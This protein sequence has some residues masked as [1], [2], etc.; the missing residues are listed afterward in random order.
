ML[1]HHAGGVE[2]LVLLKLL[3][4]DLL[5]LFK[6]DLELFHLDF[7][8]LFNPNLLVLFKLNFLFN[9]GLQAFLFQDLDFQLGLG[10]LAPPP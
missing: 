7:L 5:G 6:L 8:E 10:Q 2:D 3:L 4:S 9:L 1:R